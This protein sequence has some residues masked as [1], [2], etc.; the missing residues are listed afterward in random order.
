MNV[1]EFATVLVRYEIV[2]KRKSVTKAAY[3]ETKEEAL[4]WAYSSEARVRTMG[5]ELVLISAEVATQ[6]PKFWDIRKDYWNFRASKLQ[7]T[8]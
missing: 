6:D 2:I 7:K 8:A 1:V 5:A 3:F 4:E